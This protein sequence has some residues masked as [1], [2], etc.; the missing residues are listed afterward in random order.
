M[1]KRAPLM[2]D[3]LANL[4]KKG[5]TPWH[6]KLPADLLDELRQVKAAFEEGAMPKATRTGLAFAL[7]KSLKA[8]GID[9][10]HRGVEQW[11]QTKS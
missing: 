1:A 5:T 9:I 7:S 4:P 11:L 3:V 10:G 6:Q 8:R 2:D